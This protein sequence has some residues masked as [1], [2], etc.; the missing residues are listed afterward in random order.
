RYR[1]EHAQHICEKDFQRFKDLNVIASVQPSHLFSDAKTASEILE[2]YETEHNYKKLFDIGA[3]VCF[4]TDFPVVNESPF[5]TI[6]YA[7]T[8]K[9]ED[10]KDGFVP[11][12]KISLEDCL[13]A[14]TANNAYASFEENLR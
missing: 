8:R 6:Y 7:M 4:G 11:E 1:I 14:Y 10:F 2:D 3:K 13:E 9:T 5:E 12:N